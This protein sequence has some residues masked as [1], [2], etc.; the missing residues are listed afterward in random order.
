MRPKDSSRRVTATK[1][2]AVLLD[3]I[4]KA[5]TEGLD[6]IEEAADYAVALVITGLVNSTGSNQRFVAAFVEDHLDE[7]KAALE[8]QS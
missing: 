8:R 6:T 1:E 5:E 3:L 2:D 7:F 4:I